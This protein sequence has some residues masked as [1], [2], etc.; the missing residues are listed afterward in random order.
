[1]KGLSLSFCPLTH[2]LVLERVVALDEGMETPVVESLNFVDCVDWVLKE[3]T[4]EGA[5]GRFLETIGLGM[6]WTGWGTC[7]MPW[8]VKLPE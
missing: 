8:E 5:L 7:L 3:L 4:E 2:S 1:M 6:L